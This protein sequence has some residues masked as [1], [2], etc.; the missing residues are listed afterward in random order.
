WP[1]FSRFVGQMVT[2]SLPRPGEEQLDLNVSVSDG[3]ARLSAIVG[4]SSSVAPD[5]ELSAK[6]LGTDGQAIETELQPSGPNRYEATVPLPAE[7]VY[8]A[9]VTAYAQNSGGSPE[10]KEPLASQTIGLV[11][12]YSAEYANLNADLSLL[13]DL[14]VATGGQ[15]LQDPAQSFAHN[16]AIGR[17]TWPVWPTL[18]LLAALLFPLDVAIRR[19]RLG[20]REWQ[21]AQAWLRERLP[22]FRP[23]AQLERSAIP[24]SPTVQAFRH[25][26]QRVRS[27]PIP[28]PPAAASG[29]APVEPGETAS[30]A[31]VSPSL[32]STSPADGQGTLARLRAAKKRAR[33]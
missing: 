10:N 7:G 17:Q 21:Q 31:S 22:G 23:A 25:A 20:W 29:A 15:T 18:L 2:W 14:P 6:L 9:Q 12:P 11:A 13:A 32:S 3:Q 24:A 26:Q 1:D 33:R 8:L 27:Q 5:L 4:D 19:L 28:P 30:P 16:L